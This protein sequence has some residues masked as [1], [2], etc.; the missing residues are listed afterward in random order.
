MARPEGEFPELPEDTNRVMQIFRT[1]ANDGRRE[2]T[3]RE[4][5]DVLD[6]AGVRICRSGMAHSEDEAVAVAEK[7]GYP[8][9]MKMTSKTTS[10]KTDVG[11]VRVGI[12]SEEDL[13]R[14]YR[15]LIGKLEAKGLLEG[16]EGVLIQ[17]MVKSK[18]EL[19]TGIATDPQFGPMVMFGLGGVFVEVLKD[20]AFRLAPLT[21]IDAKDLIHSVKCVKLLEGARGFTPAQM[22]KVEE[23]LLRISQLAHV[24]RFVKELDINPLMISDK[25]GEPIAV[26]AR[27]AFDP[28]AVKLAL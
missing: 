8:V 19:V 27:I 28:E 22:D 18:R 24:H 26:D 2:L 10:H 12:A 3:T 1:A 5:L 7:T 6:A 17:E 21:D 14:E 25:D 11:G 4:S 20:V 9:V 16:L 13:R 23:T 15:D